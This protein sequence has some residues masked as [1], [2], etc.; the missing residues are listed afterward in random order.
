MKDIKS[1]KQQTK[2]N[3]DI[4][5]LLKTKR[6]IKLP[7]GNQRKKRHFVQKN[8]SIMTAELSEILKIL[9]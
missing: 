7:S 6:K 5:K 4:V 9:S 8:E 1:L 3:Y 2:P